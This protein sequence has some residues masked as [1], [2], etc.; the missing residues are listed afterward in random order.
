VRV[1]QRRTNVE[2]VRVQNPR[3]EHQLALLDVERE[4]HDIDVAV[5]DG[6]LKPR[7]PQ[8]AAVVV[9]PDVVRLRCNLVRIDHLRAK[10]SHNTQQVAAVK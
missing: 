8:T 4:P 3:L 1:V 6:Q 9:H 5:S 7:L 10:T 2:L